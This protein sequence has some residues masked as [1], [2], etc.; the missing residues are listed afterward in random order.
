M[1]QVAEYDTPRGT[2]QDM[3]YCEYIIWCWIRSFFM[4]QRDQ[5]QLDQVKV[6]FKP[7]YI[8]FLVD[9]FHGFKV[10]CLHDPYPETQH[11]RILLMTKYHRDKLRVEL[12]STKDIYLF[13][14]IKC[15]QLNHAWCTSLVIRAFLT[16]DVLAHKLFLQIPRGHFFLGGWG[17]RNCLTF[18][19][20][21]AEIIS[22][23]LIQAYLKFC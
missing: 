1:N 20:Q 3:K 16:V 17:W 6:F 5:W 14:L 13:V 9:L 22:E 4:T 7:I 10:L 11:D 23:G 12:Y 18:P 15:H 2:S 19:L 8:L 21:S